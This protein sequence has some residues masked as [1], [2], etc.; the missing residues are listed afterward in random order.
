MRFAPEVSRE[1]HKYAWVPFGGG[2]HM[3][4]GLHFATMQV[5]VLVAQLLSRYRIELEPGAGEKWQFFPIP[6]PRDGLPVR[7]VPLNG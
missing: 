5:R 1:R 4:L 3:C 6:R 7:F 2:A